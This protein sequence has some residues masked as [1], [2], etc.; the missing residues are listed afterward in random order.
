[1]DNLRGSA[2]KAKKALGWTPKVGF[3]QL[4]AMM[5]SGDLDRAKREKVLVDNGYI[6]SH[7][8]P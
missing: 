5:V 2:E 1:M 4:V 7:Q 8:Q 3:K 6:D